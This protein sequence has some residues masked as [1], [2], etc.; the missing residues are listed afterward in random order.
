MPT[1]G[2]SYSLEWTLP[3]GKDNQH[4]RIVI[5]DLANFRKKLLGYRRSRKAHHKRLSPIHLFRTQ[6]LQLYESLQECL[7][8]PKNDFEVSLMTYDQ[9]RRRLVTTHGIKN[10]HGLDS[11]TWDFWLPFG[12]GLAGSCFKQGSAFILKR[13]PAEELGRD[14]DYYLPI[15]GRRRPK[16]LTTIPLN[17]PIFKRVI[18]I[19]R[20]GE[21]N[22][23]KAP[24]AQSSEIAEMYKQLYLNLLREPSRQCIGVINITSMRHSPAKMG[25]TKMA[26][27]VKLSHEFC[28]DV[29]GSL[30]LVP[31][32]ASR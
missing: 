31:D 20:K 1:V 3:Q 26:Q 19:Y 22:G 9:K 23:C 25:R 28:A 32:F 24:K 30:P 6:F 11:R 13:E 27:I 2:S 12:L 29:Y 4:S 10:G 16:F 8:I 5:A 18:E 15:A 17:H 7:G 14:L 21:R